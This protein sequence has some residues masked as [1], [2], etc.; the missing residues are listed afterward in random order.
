MSKSPTGTSWEA[1]ASVSWEAPQPA[2]TGRVSSPHELTNTIAKLTDALT[3]GKV[4][5]FS[6]DSIII[7][8]SSPESPDLTVIDLPGIVRTVT[9]GQDQVVISQVNDLINYYISQPRTIILAVIPSNQDIATIDILERASLID[10]EGIRTIGVLTKPDLIGPGGEEEV[11]HVL[12]NVRKPL[13][14]GYIMVKNPSQKE[15]CKS[16]CFDIVKQF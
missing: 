15:V 11:I 3:K 5:G 10:T 14:L 8:I 4:N 6:T 12:R 2:G 9:S 1:T 13:K 16:Y 7:R